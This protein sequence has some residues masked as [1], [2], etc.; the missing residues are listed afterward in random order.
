MSQE[1]PRG[2]IKTIGQNSN[3]FMIKSQES[4][5]GYI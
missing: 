1:A 2:H 3:P 5:K 4:N